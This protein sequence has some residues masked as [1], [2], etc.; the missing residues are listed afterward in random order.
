MI[1]IIVAIA[2]NNAIGRNNDLLWHIPEDMKR[3]KQITTGHK[4]IMGKRTYESLPYRPLKNRTSIVISDI[5]GDHYEGC[6][7]AYSIQEAMDHC[8]SMR[9]VSSLAVAWSTSSSCPWPI[10]YTSPG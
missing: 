2:E 5:P 10:N 7:M 1:S 6:V 4:I 8:P 3:F 9:N